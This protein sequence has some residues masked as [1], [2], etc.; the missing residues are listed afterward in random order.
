MAVGVTML[1][2]LSGYVATARDLRAGGVTWRSI[3]SYPILRRVRDRNELLLDDGRCLVSPRQEPLLT[4]FRE[5]WVQRRYL[6][7]EVAVTSTATIIDIG[8]NVGVFTVWAAALVPEGRVF[9]VEPARA[10][11]ASLQG[12]VARNELSN[13]ITIQGAISHSGGRAV[14]FARGPGVL[15][16]VFEAD[17]YGSQFRKLEEVDT[18]SLDD[19]FARCGI[20]RCALL[21]LDCEGSEY[22]ILLHA[23]AATL[24][25]IGAMAVEYHV[26]LNEHSPDTLRR[27]LTQNGFRCRVEPP[28]DV[29]GGYLYA[30]RDGPKG[31]LTRDWRVPLSCRRCS[32]V[33]EC[34]LA[35]STVRRVP[36]CVSR[37]GE[38][39]L[40]SFPQ[41]A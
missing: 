16:T 20:G 32:G 1:H 8:A 30:W 21:K 10:M 22:D 26:G 15:N 7:P 37:S 40:P 27:F 41:I 36:A 11:Y 25:R 2:R 24:E 33:H 17:N 31:Q 5:V 28:Q 3:L 19:L 14:L 38:S 35:T 39:A 18:L 12:N 34:C 6:P 9:A 23:S 13:V 4:L 29:E